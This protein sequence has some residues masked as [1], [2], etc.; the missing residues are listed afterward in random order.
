MMLELH[1]IKIGELIHDLSSWADGGRMV[2]VTGAKG[3]GKTTL[4]CSV[5]G[6]LP[7]DGGHISID[8][9]LLT[10][11]SAPYFRRQMAYVPQHLS[12]IEGYD[13]MCYL[14]EVLFTLRVNSGSTAFRLPDDNRRLSELTPDEQYLLPLNNALQLGRPMLIVDEPQM[15][16]TE[17]TE[18]VVDEML[19]SA[20]ER[21]ITVFA[22]NSRITENQIRL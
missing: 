7:I 14:S 5:M 3:C 9:E 11:L 16:L 6:L 18:A 19:T 17:E 22:V 21:G 4:L 1:N 20:S 2:T 12:A 8:G 13:G 15:P 10:P